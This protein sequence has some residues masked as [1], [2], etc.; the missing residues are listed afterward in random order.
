[1]EVDDDEDEFPLDEPEEVILDAMEDDEEDDDS[2]PVKLMSFRPARGPPQP[3]L[4][5]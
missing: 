3:L 5:F 2:M 4:A 1:M